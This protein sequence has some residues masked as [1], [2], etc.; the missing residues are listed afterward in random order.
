MRTSTKTVLGL[1]GVTI[2]AVFSYLSARA[3]SNEAKVRAE[4]AYVTLQAAV[5]DLKASVKDHDEALAAQA[6]RTE[7]LED[8][9]NARPMYMKAQVEPRANAPAPPAQFM[10]AVEQYKAKK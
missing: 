4:V 3:E 1:A 2:P 6:A 9:L 8:R 5:V 7:A 10:E